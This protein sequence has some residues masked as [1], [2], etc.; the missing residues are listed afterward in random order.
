MIAAIT[1][2][3]AINVNAQVNDELSKVKILSTRDSNVIKM[4]YAMKTDEPIQVRFITRDGEFQRDKIRGEFAKGVSKRY[5]VSGI[6]DKDFWMEIS[7]ATMTV[8]YKINRSTDR[9]KFEPVLEK[10]VHNHL[11]VASSLK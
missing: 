5:D 2:F 3:G 6:K 8:T 11:A 4:L 9:S 1:A 10:S 7:S